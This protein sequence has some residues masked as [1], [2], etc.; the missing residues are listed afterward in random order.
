MKADGASFTL[1]GKRDTILYGTALMA[2]CQTDRQT[3][4]PSLC[5]RLGRKCKSQKQKDTYY[6]LQ[7][8]LLP[9][10]SFVTKVQ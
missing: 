6:F 4:R 9:L 2:H 8:M 7:D 3:D 10:N 5:I 1:R